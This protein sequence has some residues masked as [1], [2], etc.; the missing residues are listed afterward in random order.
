MTD[1]QDALLPCPFCGGE[2]ITQESPYKYT[3]ICENC[4]ARG[5]IE[6]PVLGCP[7]KW[8]TRAHLTTMREDG[9]GD[10]TCIDCPEWMGQKTCCGWKDKALTADNAK[11]GE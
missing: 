5:P 10:K 11:R 4:L 7:T 1:K 6:N 3:A 2:K 9:W 8:N